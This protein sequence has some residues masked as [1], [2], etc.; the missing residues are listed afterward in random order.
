MGTKYYWNALGSSE[1]LAAG[2][3]IEIGESCWGWKFLFHGTGDIRSWQEWKKLLQRG[4][5][6]YDQYKRVLSPRELCEVVETEQGRDHTEFC[7][8]RLPRPV[9]RP[10][11]DKDGFLF[12]EDDIP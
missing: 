12:T 7:L 8:T 6:I 11:H 10:W 4:G 3:S 5:V 2:S 1:A 9:S